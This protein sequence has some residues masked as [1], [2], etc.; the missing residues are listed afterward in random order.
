[1][2]LLTD[3][4]SLIYPHLCLACGKALF[5]RELTICTYCRYDLPKTTLHLEPN[6]KLQKLFWGKVPIE[7]ATALLYFNKGSKVQKLIHEL[8]YRGKT[9]VGVTIGKMLG[10]ALKTAPAFQG[11]TAVVPVPLHPKKERQ[12]GYNQSLFIAVGVAESLGVPYFQNALVRT[13]FTE[14]QTKKSLFDRW[15]NVNTVF[16][17]TEPEA[18]Q[19]QSI[20]LVDDV[21]TT[22]STLESCAQVLLQV[23][24]TKVSVA[25]LA[26][27]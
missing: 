17:V 5:D 6:N 1:M 23:P 24:Q 11:I 14:S 19:N 22:G 16:K 3:F 4:I 20:L 26:C 18:L 25:T 7:A 8:K 10:S 12:R 21:I 9:D 2:S 15:K 27:A 13:L